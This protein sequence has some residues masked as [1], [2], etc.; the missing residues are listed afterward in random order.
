MRDSGSVKQL[1][2]FLVVTAVIVAGMVYYHKVTPS[3]FDGKAFFG[4]SRAVPVVPLPV[5]PKTGIVVQTSRS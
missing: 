2:I 4:E 5:T 1:I 3:P